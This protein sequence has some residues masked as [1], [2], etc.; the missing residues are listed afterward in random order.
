M[1][2]PYCS[3]EYSHTHFSLLP[4]QK[5]GGLFRIFRTIE[6]PPRSA[7]EGYDQ[8]IKGVIIMLQCSST[9]AM[10]FHDQWQGILNQPAE[11]SSVF[12]LKLT[13]HDCSDHAMEWF[14]AY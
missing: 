6:E 8:Y 7:P 12:V 3:L 2:T 9:N 13:L 14:M 1:P 11:Y 4:G 5:G 10:H